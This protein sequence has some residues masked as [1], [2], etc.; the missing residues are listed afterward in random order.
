MGPWAMV[1]MLAA[2]V[3]MGSGAVYGATKLLTGALDHNWRDCTCN[4]CMSR[5][6]RSFKRM[7][8][9]QYRLGPAPRV[10]TTQL[11]Q[12]NRVY[13]KSQ[14]YKVLSATAEP[15]GGMLVVLSHTE[16]GVVA[17]ARIRWHRI[18]DP[19]WYKA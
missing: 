13:V 14:A 16:T 9:L 5:R 7:K 3:V 10:P 8:E 17:R 11:R 15:D 1:A 2:P 12:G 4:E 6:E 19:L 18:E